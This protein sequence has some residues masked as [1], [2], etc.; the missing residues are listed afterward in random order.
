MQ[1]RW[2]REMAEEWS[3]RPGEEEWLGV[4]S[5]RGWAGAGVRLY[6]GYISAPKRRLERLA[7]GKRRRSGG[8]FTVS[9][10]RCEETL[11]TVAAKA[12]A[13]GPPWPGT[14]AEAKISCGGDSCGSACPSRRLGRFRGRARLSTFDAGSAAA[15]SQIGSHRLAVKRAGAGP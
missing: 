7:R 8:L 2:S 13:E 11:F 10:R 12:P 15:C 6:L 3:W 4:A 5:G 1:P 9:T 14:V